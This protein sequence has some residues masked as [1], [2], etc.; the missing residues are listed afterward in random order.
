MNDTYKESNEAKWKQVA[1]LVGIKDSS[2]FGGGVGYMNM[3]KSFYEAIKKRS[4]ENEKALQWLLNERI[5]SLVGSIIRMELDSLFRLCYFKVQSE[6]IKKQLLQQ[7]MKGQ[8]WRGEKDLISDRTMVQ[9][10]TGQL[11]LDWATPIY[12]IGCAFIH[13]SPYHDWGGVNEPTRNINIEIRRVI[14]EHIKVHHHVELEEG[15]TFEDLVSVASDVFGKI[16]GNLLYE[17][18]K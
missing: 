1:K 11:L 7:F 10:L 6:P 14:V 12:D 16:R 4:D 15:F 13:L 18:N 9:Y 2:L 3:T 5:Y 8:R 17:L